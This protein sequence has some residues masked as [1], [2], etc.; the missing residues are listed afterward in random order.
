[1]EKNAVAEKI[2]ALLE[3]EPR[4]QEQA[5]HFVANA[6]TFTVGRLP[7]HRHVSALELLGG[8]RDYAKLEFGAVAGMVLGEW[9]LQSASDIGNVVY[10]L[11]GTELL[12][13]S[14]EDRPEDFICDF[15]LCGEAVPERSAAVV[16]PKID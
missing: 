16:L 10:L 15:P 1:M 6:V 13:A 7:E 14:P 3:K 2:A 8:V 12:S 11:I 4:Y 9:G 5:Y